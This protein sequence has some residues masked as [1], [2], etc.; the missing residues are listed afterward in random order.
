VRAGLLALALSGCALGTWAVPQPMI[1]T[2]QLDDVWT[3]MRTAVTAHCGGI[4]TE[5]S[6]AK[7][8]IGPWQAWHSG[9]GLYL[10]RC[11]VSVLSDEDIERFVTVR[12][13]FVAKRCGTGDLDHLDALAKT[14]EP[15][16]TIPQ[17]VKTELELLTTKF[18]ADVR[19]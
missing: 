19:R 10:T 11:M 3:R 7:L 12:L 17:L 18:E 4:E 14:C 13:T 1:R 15:A 5:N 8:L 2:G 16:D 9:D 6:E